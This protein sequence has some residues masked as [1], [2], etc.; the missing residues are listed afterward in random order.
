MTRLLLRMTVSPSLIP[1]MSAEAMESHCDLLSGVCERDGQLKT[2]SPLFLC[3]CYFIVSST[4]LH[5]SFY[6]FFTYPLCFS[7]FL[8][9]SSHLLTFHILY[10]SVLLSLYIFLSYSLPVS[11]FHPVTNSLYRPNQI[12]SVYFEFNFM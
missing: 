11:L 9:P 8:F 12:N 4:Q 3:L 2:P 10:L 7:S 5:S 1:V 6:H